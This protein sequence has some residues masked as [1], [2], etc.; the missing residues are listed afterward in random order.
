VRL[1]AFLAAA[2]IGCGPTPNPPAS[3]VSE[4]AVSTGTHLTADGV[5]LWYR[6]VGTGSATV[7][8]PAANYF[9]TLIDSLASADRRIVLYD[10]R[11]RGRSDSVTAD[12][13]G[14]E[15]D[16][17]DL[18]EIREAV[19]APSVTILAWSG[20]AVAATRYALRHPDRVDRLVLIAPVGPRWHPYWDSMR[21]NA[22]ARVDT[23]AAAALERRVAAGAFARDQAGLCRAR[24]A[25]SDA[26][27][28][29]DSAV[30]RRRPDVC[31]S[32]NEWPDRYGIYV[33]RLLRTL[34]GYDLRPDLRRLGQP[35]LVI[36]GVRDNIPV[37]AS[38]EW[39]ASAPTA[40]LLLLEG[41]GH[42]PHLE[43]PATV[44]AALRA[45]ASGA[46]PEGTEPR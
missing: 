40:R 22:R 14:V 23:G 8:V 1:T 30:A 2:I 17:A 7:I 11:G 46:W 38:R 20:I 35:L 13:T 37:A 32:P 26:T 31:D 43:Q 9:T 4:P 18:D 33:G 36:H 29:A 34:E 19:G 21:V 12:H 28:F 16:V 27:G 41:V 24:A 6:I 39:V 10:S 25:L 3:G 15:F 5:R 42:W 45:F 44:L